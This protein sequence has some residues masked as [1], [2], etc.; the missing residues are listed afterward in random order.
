M[1]NF[2]KLFSKKNLKPIVNFGYMPLGNG[3]LKKK[4]KNEYKFQMKVGYNQ[5]LNLF[6]LYHNPNPKKMFNENYAF[7]SSTSNSMKV[8]FQNY[9]NSLKKMI[10]KKKFSVLEV[11]CNDG[12]LL[13]NFKN[14]DHLG[15]EPSKNVYKISKDKKLNVINKFFNLELT[16]LNSLKGKK[17]DIICGANVFC[18]IPNLEELFKTAEFFLAE[19]GIFSIEEPYLGDVIEKGSYDQIYDEHIYIFSVHSINK[20]AN[21]FN[22]EVYHAEKQ[23]THG[24]SMRYYLSKKNSKFKTKKLQEIK[25]W[26]IKMGLNN[27][28]KILNFKKKCEMSKKIFFNKVKKLALKNELYGYGATSKSTTILNYCNVDNKYIKGIFDTTYTKI[29]KFTPGTNI[30]ILDYKNKFKLIKPKICILF[31][32]NHF[33]EICEKEKDQLNRGLKFLIHIDKKHMKGYKKYFL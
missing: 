12:I 33:K 19:N 25:N 20:I 13:D 1:Q 11:G 24:G 18:H 30:P 4:I 8:H 27:Y 15:V 10:N 26:E 31:A 3:F 7:L 21:F 6:Q 23:T 14:Q 22:L 16:K 29:D 2:K 28:K 9:A 17:Y 32:W 5:K